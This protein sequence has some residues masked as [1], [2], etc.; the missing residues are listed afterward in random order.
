MFGYEFVMV[1]SL[2]IGVGYI[3]LRWMSVIV[4]FGF[5]LSLVCRF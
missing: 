5:F 2:L 4:G 3:C 1:L